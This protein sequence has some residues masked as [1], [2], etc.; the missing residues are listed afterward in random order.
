MPENNEIDWIAVEGDAELSESEIRFDPSRGMVLKP[1]HG[2]FAASPGFKS[3]PYCTLV[4][5]KY[6][7]RGRIRFQAN[8][9]GEDCRCQVVL[10]YRLQTLILAGLNVGQAA[11]GIVTMTQTGVAGGARW[12]NLSSAKVGG[13]PAVKTPLAI[14][15]EVSGSNLSLLVDSVIVASAQTPIQISRVQLALYLEGN[16][17]ITIKDFAVAAEK[18]KAFIV[19]QFK[20]PYNTLYSEVIKPGCESFGYEVVRADDMYTTGLIIREITQS[21]QE[22]SVIVADITPESPNVYYEVGYAHALNKPTILLSDRTEERL[23]F[24][25]S[26]FRTLFYE[27]SIGGKRKV[28]EALK[29]HL[30]NVTAV[31]GASS[32]SIAGLQ[33]S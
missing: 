14:D 20:E 5:S 30:E 22:A 6:F 29:K 8:I 24:D 1:E 12:E 17:P 9:E 19:M 10:N 16:S 2:A 33:T 23:P 21:I 26:G 4:S 3:I 31:P 27:D 28:E 11:Y 7:Q 13:H 25:I 15:V 18:P 32:L